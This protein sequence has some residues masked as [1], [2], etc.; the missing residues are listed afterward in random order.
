VK[1]RI[2]TPS[3]AF[4]MTVVL[5][6]IEILNYANSTSRRKSIYRLLGA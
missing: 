1:S 4:A 6:S 3:S 2:F 5:I